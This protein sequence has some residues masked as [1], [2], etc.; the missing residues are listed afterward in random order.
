MRFREELYGKEI[1]DKDGNTIGVVEDVELSKQGRVT[2]VIALPRGIVSRLTRQKLDIK[3]EDI[4]A[5]SQV[6]IL[7][8]NEEELRGEFRCGECGKVFSSEQA[9]KAH[10]AKEHARQNKKQAMKKSK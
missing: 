8:K 4:Q 9:R 5:L 6:V 10:V 1:I 7:N 3:F 2:H